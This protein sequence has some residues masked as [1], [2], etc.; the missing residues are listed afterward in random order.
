MNKIFN[1]LILLFIP[2]IF[3]DTPIA[4]A[5]KS[6]AD[7]EKEFNKFETEINKGSVNDPL[8]KY[9]RKVFEFNETVD[10]Y[11]FE[12]I[13]RNYRKTIPKPTRSSIR[14]FL[15]NLTLPVSAFNSFAQGKP[16]NGFATISSFLINSTLGIGGLFNIAKVK[17]IKYESEDFG[18]TLGYYGLESNIFLI[19]PFIGPNNL[20]DLSGGIVD[21]LVDP[22][23]FNSFEIGGSSDFIEAKY[24]IANSVGGVIDTREELLDIIDIVRKDSFDTYATIR[25]AY[26]QRRLAEIEK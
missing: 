12:K 16:E 24:R 13:A 6:D 25:S 14:N 8:E 5:Q 23:S 22:L 26:L 11:F 17:G 3:I 7:F 20:R 9:N 4:H 18:Q 21:R 1:F 2:I 15:T 10:K 19:L